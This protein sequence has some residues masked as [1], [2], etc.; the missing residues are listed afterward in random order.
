MECFICREKSQSKCSSCHQ[1][2]CSECMDLSLVCLSCKFSKL[3][4]FDCLKFLQTRVNSQILIKPIYLY[5]P[6]IIFKFNQNEK[7]AILNAIE[8]F[9][10]CEAGCTGS[11]AHATRICPKNHP[12]VTLFHN[13]KKYNVFRFKDNYY[14]L[15]SGTMWYVTKYTED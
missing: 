9:F 3:N 8:H 11:D 10:F 5:L 12:L 13:K 15:L 4:R 14:R 6:K 7:K 1:R 2:V